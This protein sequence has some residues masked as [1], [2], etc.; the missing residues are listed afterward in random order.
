[1]LKKRASSEGGGGGWKADRIS[2]QKRKGEK[3]GVMNKRGG[4]SREK[5]EGIN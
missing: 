4:K 2:S 5:P 1:M 3:G